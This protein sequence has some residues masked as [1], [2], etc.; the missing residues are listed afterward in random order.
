M[1]DINCITVT[2]IISKKYKN[3]ANF[4]CI[5]KICEIVGPLIHQ[6]EIYPMNYITVKDHELF[7]NF[8]DLTYTSCINNYT[9]T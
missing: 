8:T 9:T 2:S 4:I 5:H 1:S 7:L 3:E 6:I